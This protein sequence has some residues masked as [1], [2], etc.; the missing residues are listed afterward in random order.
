MTNLDLKGVDY[1]EKVEV[2]RSPS[3]RRV[4]RKKVS[5]DRGRE[6]NRVLAKVTQLI[7]LLTIFLE[8]LLGFRV[9][10]RMIAANPANPFAA[11]IYNLSAPFVAPFVGLTVTPN[12]EGFVFEFMTVIG[13]LVYGLVSWGLIQLIWIVFRQVSTRDVAIYEAEE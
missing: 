9:M 4:V 12:Y 13:M 7:T 8:A 2:N 6:R 1:Q 10:L 5:E 3:G 11:F